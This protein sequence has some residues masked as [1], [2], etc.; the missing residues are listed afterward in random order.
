M[1]S[2]PWPQP[3]FVSFPHGDAILEG[4]DLDGSLR[5]KVTILKEFEVSG[6]QGFSVTPRD[7]SLPW[8]SS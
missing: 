4:S 7:P 8:L 5:V 3:F 6:S 2:M 1:G